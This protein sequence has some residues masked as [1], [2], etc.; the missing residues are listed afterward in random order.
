M[1]DG[2]SPKKMMG[3]AKGAVV[4]LSADEDRDRPASASVRASRMP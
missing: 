3:R 4:K 2:T 1:P